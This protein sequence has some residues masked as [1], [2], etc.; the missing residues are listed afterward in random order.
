MDVQKQEIENIKLVIDQ[1]VLIPRFTYEMQKNAPRPEGEYA[2]VRCLQSLNPGFDESKII[3]EPDGSQSFRTRGARVL[4]FQIVFSRDGQEYINFDN[5]FFRPDVLA[6]C[7]KLKIAPMAKT[8]LDLATLQLETN[9]EVRKAVKMQFNVL[10]EQS[11]P[12]GI[13]TDA[14]VSGQVHDD[15]KVINTKGK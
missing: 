3:D 6:L 10:R 11:T 13:M 14:I 15:G 5:S 4:T 1:C 8:T 7:K 9:W 2:A 12:I